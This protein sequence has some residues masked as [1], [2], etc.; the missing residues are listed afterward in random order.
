MTSSSSVTE[1]SQH[2]RFFDLPSE[3][4]VTIHE[5]IL[6]LPN[7]VDLDPTNYQNIAP[8]LRLFLVSRRMHE[9]AYRTFYGGNTF[10]L[11][12]LHGRFFHTK[13]PL[14]SRIPPRYRATMNTIELRLGPG[15]TAPPKGWVVDQHIGLSDAR[16]LR[17]LKIFVECDPASDDIFEGFR[18]GHD[19]YTIFCRG[20]V[21]KIY[22]YVPSLDEVQ[23]NA[24]PS[25]P[26]NS[27]LMQ[28]LLR[29]AAISK[30]RITW[31]L[32]GG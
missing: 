2:F 20:L 4:R 16:A 12:P 19:F 21:K 18:V 14:L 28:A 32:E 13:L 27:P 29:E 26:K 8:R 31:G 10:R 1:S 11:F 25:V 15:W 9:E 7:T 23:F 24:Y 17:L 30:K 6:L 3:L 5:L 22:D